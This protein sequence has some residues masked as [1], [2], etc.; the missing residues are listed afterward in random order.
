MV[1]VAG[2]GEKSP[3][4][5][6]NLVSK[7]RDSEALWRIVEIH[8][9]QWKI[10]E[11]FRFLKQSYDLEDRGFLGYQ[12]L[13]NLVALVAAATHFAAVFLGQK[14]K[15]RLL[16]EKLLIICLRFFGIPPFRFYALADGIHNVLSPLLILGLYN[17]S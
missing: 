14:L 2:F 16:T 7:A 8:L 4:L 11:T 13:Q 5:L 9:K 17:C 10:E 12:R 3:M 1:V 6:T 15:L